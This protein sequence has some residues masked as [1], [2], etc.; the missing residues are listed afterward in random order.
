MGYGPCVISQCTDEATHKRL[1]LCNRHTQQYR[2]HKGKRAP[3]AKTQPP[4]MGC[5]IPNC[6]YRHHSSGYCHVH[7]SRWKSRG[8]PAVFD[9][10]P[11]FVL[12]ECKLYGCTEPEYICGYCRNHYQ[13]WTRAGRPDNWRPIPR[14]AH[15]KIKPNWHQRRTTTQL[16]TGCLV[17]GCQEPHYSNGYCAG[18]YERWRNRGRPPNWIGP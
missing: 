4:P 11:P 3:V 13:G 18:D 15:A 10:G 5:K 1:K 12:A 16:P 7:Y 6:P 2:Y 17:L 14:E 9:G 8:R